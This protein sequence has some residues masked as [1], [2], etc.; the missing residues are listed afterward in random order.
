MMSKG[1][2]DHIPAEF[3]TA[4]L[5]G[6]HLGSQESHKGE[7]GIE[8]GLSTFWESVSVLNRRGNNS[9][10]LKRKKVNLCALILLLL[11]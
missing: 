7:K 11:E 4:W 1:D 5:L 6:H 10:N 9:T 3:S 2:W 8:S